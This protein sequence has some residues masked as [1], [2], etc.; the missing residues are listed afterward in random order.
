MNPWKSG[1]GSNYFEWDEK[2]NKKKMNKLVMYEKQ[3]V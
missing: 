3:N 2:M 1:E